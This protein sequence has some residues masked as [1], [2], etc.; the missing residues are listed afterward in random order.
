[1]KSPFPGMDPYL[2]GFRWGDFH[3]VFVQCWR[4][5]ILDRLP[6]ELDA[7]L[8]EYVSIVEPGDDVKRI[9]PDVYVSHSTERRGAPH[10]GAGQSS[11]DVAVLEPVTMTIE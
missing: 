10:A 4:E 9:I 11:A 8:G 5:A 7:E 2:E 6:D 1:M 3:S